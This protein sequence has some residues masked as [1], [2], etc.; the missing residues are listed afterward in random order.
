MTAKIIDGKATSERIRVEIK[1][2][3]RAM[4]AEGR[5]APGLATVLVGENAA[6]QVYVRMKHRACAEAGIESFGYELPEDAS[7]E[8]VEKLVRELNEDSRVDGILVQLPLPAGLDEE[9]VL[10]TVSLSKDVDGFHPV[11]IGRLAQKGREPLFIPCTPYGVIYLLKET[12]PTLGRAK[13]GGFG[14][15]QYRGHA[16]GPAAGARERHCNDLPFTHK[17]LE[18]CCP[19]GRYIDCGGGKAGDGEEG[20]GQ[21]GRRGDRCGDEPRGGTRTQTGL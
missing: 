10:N 2:E 18:R 16:G 5:Q 7:Q 9:K 1:E 11:N 21:A 15:I 6:S 8:E 3:V 12:L 20:L 4:L 13:C 19:S 14:T 17:R